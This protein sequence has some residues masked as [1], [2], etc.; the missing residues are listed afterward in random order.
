MEVFIRNLPLQT[1]EDEIRRHVE[2]ALRGLSISQ[3]YWEVLRNKGCAKLT[4]LDREKGNRFL[5]LYGSGPGRRAAQLPIILGGKRIQ[6]LQSRNQPAAHI[7]RALSLGQQATSTTEASHPKTHERPSRTFECSAIHCGVWDYN[8]QDL[9]FISHFQDQS[10]WKAN[11][12][13]RSCTIAATLARRSPRLVIPYSSVHSLTVGSNHQPSFTLSLTEA[14]RISACAQ[15][16]S[17][18]VEDASLDNLLR[19]L[20]KFNPSPTRNR[21]DR[22]RISGLDSQHA[23][24]AA[25][26]LVYR[27]L[28]KNANDC[29]RTQL[30]RKARDLPPNISHETALVDATKSFGNE[31]SDLHTE[32]SISY[33]GLSFRI[34]FQLQKLAQNGLLQPRLVRALLPIAVEVA[35][36]SGADVAAQVFQKLENHISFPG[37][38]TTADEI[39]VQALTSIVMGLEKT[40]KWEKSHLGSMQKESEQHALIHKAMVTPTGVHLDGPHLDTKNRV[41]RKYSSH[42]DHFLRVIFCD[43]DWEPCRFDREVSLAEIFHER[44]QNV[45]DV[46]IN[47]AGLRF[48][49]LG[50]SHSSLRAASCWFMAPFVDNGRQLFAGEVIRGLGDFSKFRSPAKCA[51]RIG[52]AFSDTVSSIPIPLESV[53]EIE[54][55]VRNGSTFSDG[56][57]TISPSILRLIWNK[58]GSSRIPKPTLFQFRYAGKLPVCT[59]MGFNRAFPL[60]AQIIGLLTQKVGAKGMISLDTRLKGDVICL[61]PSM[62]KFQGSRDKNLEICQAAKLLPLFLNQQYI[63]ILEDQGV[64]ESVFLEMQKQDVAQLRKS[65]SS[66]TNAANFLE[67]ESIGQ[68]AKLPFLLRKLQLIGLSFQADRFLRNAVE[69]RMLIRLREI[70]YRSRLRVEQGCVLYG[71]M[72]ET[73]FL[74]EGEVFCTFQKDNISTIVL[75]GRVVVTRPPALHPG[76][77]QT[78]QAVM[79]PEDS[80]LR[81][82]CNCIVFSQ[83][84]SRSLPSMLGG[85]DLDGDT[86]AV[87]YDTKLRPK[88]KMAPAEYLSA[89]PIDINRQVERRDITQFL[90]QFMENDQLGRI[91]MLHRS[92]ADKSLIGTSDPDCVKL[93]EM[94]ST[95][96][97]F[98][99]TGIQVRAFDSSSKMAISFEF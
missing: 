2:P 30:L 38:E 48:E 53:R 42:T 41:I 46:G 99:K 67:R 1:T 36:R 24:V 59:L 96:V 65:A 15:D 14:P 92:L 3:F 57:G 98:S 18:G 10:A 68:A 32:L 77:I 29:D 13:K 88:Y 70:K 80:P 69:L 19:S 37:P 81:E 75:T 84:G 66:P 4:I 26:C 54:D 71:I 7:L 74:K 60:R 20:L 31:I 97:D 35:R 61:R 44:F 39:A 93:A 85:G 8:R 76:D 49:F 47:I 28:L 12:G 45:L 94:H 86:Y 62:I 64:D 16:N 91:A 90:I 82:L 56:V 33:R 55:V 40:I 34:R 21:P 5:T 73:D 79:V 22:K 87:I 23:T 11:F 58:H 25:G 6:C 89:S 95:A 27:L 78:A 72:D 50:F 9:V 17:P 83:Q 51:A 63:K 52:Q 43:E